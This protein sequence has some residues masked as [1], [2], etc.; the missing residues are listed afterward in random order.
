MVSI[1]D[2]PYFP[3]NQSTLFNDNSLR[4]YRQEVSKNMTEEDVKF[5]AQLRKLVLVTL[6]N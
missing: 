3:Q 4:K 1:A 6:V 2:L 5:L